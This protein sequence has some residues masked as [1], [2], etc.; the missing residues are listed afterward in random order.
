MLGVL[1]CWGRVGAGE[2]RSELVRHKRMSTTSNATV[3]TS[4][5]AKPL[6]CCC[7]ADPGDALRRVATGRSLCRT[8]L[9]LSLIGL[10]YDA[11]GL[12]SHQIAR[13]A[14]SRDQ[15]SLQFSLENI[16]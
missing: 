6:R 5:P 8:P 14:T 13:V 2:A 3:P 7:S 9:M 10:G 4:A 15:V 11:E 16:H 12:R 1:K